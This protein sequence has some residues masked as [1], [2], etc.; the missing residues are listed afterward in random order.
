MSCGLVLSLRAQCFLGQ[1]HFSI[2][3]NDRLT[4]PHRGMTA[5]VFITLRLAI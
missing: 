3:A 4:T 5:K 2:Q 1:W